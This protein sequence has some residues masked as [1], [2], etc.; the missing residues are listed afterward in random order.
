VRS[1]AVMPAIYGT[2]SIVQALLVRSAAAAIEEY[3]A[4]QAEEPAPLAT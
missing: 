4:R 1:L 3:T 2:L